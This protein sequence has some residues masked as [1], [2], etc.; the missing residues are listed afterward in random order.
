MGT[1]RVRGRMLLAW[2]LCV[3]L[4][5]GSASA[6]AAPA[7]A[8][9][10][11]KFDAGFREGQAQFNRGEY[12]AAART[13]TAAVARLRESPDNKDNRAAVYTYI[14]EAYRKTVLGG[15][16][17]DIVREALAVLDG[18]AESHAAAYPR[19]VLP[20]QIDRQGRSSSAVTTVGVI[21]GPALLGAGVALLAIG[22]R[23]RAVGR[24]VAVAPLFGPRTAGLAAV[25][26]F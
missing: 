24:R 19:E 11:V 25:L 16:G 1:R 23:R 10:L 6:T 12:L 8:G 2:P 22:L 17:I 9:D 4:S 15:A 18:Y 3:T 5:L 26:R 14:A 7:P 21:V 13:W 20:P